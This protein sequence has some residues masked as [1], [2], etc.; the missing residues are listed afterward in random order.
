MSYDGRTVAFHSFASD[1]VAGDYNEARDVFVLRLGSGD[2]DHDGLDD[3][4][5]GTYFSTLEMGG[6]DDPDGDGAN[7]LAEFQAGTDPT[8]EGSVFQVLVLTLA[9]DWT[10]PVPRATITVFWSAVPG[11]SYRVQAKAS[12]DAPWA[13]VPGGTL[14]FSPSASKTFEVAFPPSQGFF[15]A[16]SD[17]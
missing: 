15:R 5:E 1:L 12:M 10:A 3:D 16:V 8:N 7:N 17:P 4:W 11:R 13:D 2:S 14:A 6:G 9:A